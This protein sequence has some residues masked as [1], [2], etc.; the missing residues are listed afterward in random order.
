MDK[1]ANHIHRF[2]FPLSPVSCL[3]TPALS[4]A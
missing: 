1:A 4:Y 2:S 3:L